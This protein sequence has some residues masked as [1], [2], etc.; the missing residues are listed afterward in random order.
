VPDQKHRKKH[1]RD[2]NKG[3]T[4]IFTS[5]CAFLFMAMLMVASGNLSIPNPEML[6]L[7]GLVVCASLFDFPAGAIS[8]A[9]VILFVMYF[10]SEGHSF[11][12]Y[13]P[14]NLTRVIITGCS[15][16]VIT[17]FLGKLHQIWNTTRQKTIAIVKK[18]RDS[19]EALEEE[20]HIDT[21][22]GLYNRNMLRMNYSEYRHRSLIVTLLD[23]DDFKKINDVCGHEIGDV[24]LRQLSEV[25][26]DTF[27]NTDCYRYGGD[28]FLLIR[29][30]DNL[31][32]FNLEMIRAR[33][34]LL[35]ITLGPQKLPLH[36]SVGYVSGTTE[37]G[38]DIRTMFHM[39][40]EMLYESKRQGKN[41]VTGDTFYRETAKSV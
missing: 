35:R 15:V 5:L 33:S 23:I 8:A 19:N 41:R 13:T 16:I 31:G 37:T 39:A 2:K 9:Q 3:K 14:V 4:I 34:K 38:D 26:A 40:D 11:F 21:L 27:T 6:L 30:D 1:H 29:L 17:V 32:Q 12:S 10:Y 7:A 24:A 28:E 25:L 22:T 18:L 36:I 20:S